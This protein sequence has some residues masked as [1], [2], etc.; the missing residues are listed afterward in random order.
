MARDNLPMFCY[1]S[2]YP[3]TSHMAQQYAIEE[4][5]DND[6]YGSINALR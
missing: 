6:L 5:D 4:V 2:C 1:P 3:S